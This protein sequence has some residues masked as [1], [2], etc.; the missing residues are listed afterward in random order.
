MIAEDYRIV[1][2]NNTGVSVDASSISAALK[3]AEGDGTGAVSYGTEQTGTEGSSL[4][5]G[6]SATLVTISNSTAV[7]AFGE[8]EGNLASNAATPDG[9]LDF[10]L[11]TSTD[12]GA[13]FNRSPWPVATLFYDNAKSDENSNFVL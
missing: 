13:N 1:V 7:A 8:V 3:E 2:E 9:R 4:A 11:E 10:Y 6:S 12:G 5:D